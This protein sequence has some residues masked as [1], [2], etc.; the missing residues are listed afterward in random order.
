MVGTALYYKNKSRISFKL[1]PNFLHPVGR[2]KSKWQVSCCA[3][4]AN[5]PAIGRT[6]PRLTCHLPV[7]PFLFCALFFRS[8]AHLLLQLFSDISYMHTV[9]F[10][11]FQ[12]VSYHVHQIFCT[13]FSPSPFSLVFLAFLC[14]F[15]TL[16]IMIQPPARVARENNIDL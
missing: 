4:S 3:E 10:T 15:R 8:R 1:A 11:L 5:L 14:S 16:K 13:Y 12:T 6:G 7:I 9:G 2:D